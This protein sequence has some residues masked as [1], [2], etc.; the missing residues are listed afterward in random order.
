MPT[1]L[2]TRPM[3]E[4]ILGRASTTATVAAGR[5][6]ELGDARK[7]AISLARHCRDEPRA[8]PVVLEL[9]AEVADVAI[10]QVALRD[11]ISPPE[12]VE[13]HL[14]IERLS[15]VRRQ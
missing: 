10:D 7:K 14:A 4:K 5:R 2:N 6:D 11:V 8:P 15:G 13:D 12:R 1:L 3:C 9:H